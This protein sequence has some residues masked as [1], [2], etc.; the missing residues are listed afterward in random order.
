MESQGIQNSETLLKKNKVGELKLPDSNTQQKATVIMRV[1]QYIVQRQ[2]YT[3]TEQ[4]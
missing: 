2:A 3:S 1:W 4:N